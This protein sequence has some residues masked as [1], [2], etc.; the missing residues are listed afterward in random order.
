[1]K[2][3]EEAEAPQLVKGL[4]DLHLPAMREAFATAAEQ[5]RQESL[6]YE[7]YLLE[8]VNRECDERRHKRV[9]SRRAG[10]ERFTAAAG[11]EPGDVRP[12]ASAGQGLATGAN[13][14]DG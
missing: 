9:E 11:E 7:R 1:M 8:L 2:K 13:A 4:K 3:S 14:P 6:S 10:T 5:A 12:Q